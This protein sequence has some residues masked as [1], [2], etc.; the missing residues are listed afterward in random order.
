[1][2]PIVPMIQLLGRVCGHVGSTAN[3][4]GSASAGRSSAAAM[5]PTNVILHPVRRI[6]PPILGVEFAVVE[7]RGDSCNLKPRSSASETRGPHYYVTDQS[8]ISPSLKRAG[9]KA[10]PGGS[11]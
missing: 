4:G 7:Y 1:M 11:I 10:G 5:A 8:R 2:P 9:V 6:T 3:F